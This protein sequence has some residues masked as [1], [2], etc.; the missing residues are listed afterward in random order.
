MLIWLKR[1]PLIQDF[2][3]GIDQVVYA[4]KFSF[5]YFPR[6]RPRN[7]DKF[8]QQFNCISS[9]KCYYFIDFLFLLWLMYLI[10]HHCESTCAMSAHLMQITWFRGYLQNIRWIHKTTSQTLIFINIVTH[11][12]NILTLSQGSQWIIR[13]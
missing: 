3:L 8:S 13:A 5:L 2:F 1:V 4:L 12:I 9:S 6:S 7:S 11:L 10:L